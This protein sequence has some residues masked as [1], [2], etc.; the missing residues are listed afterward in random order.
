MGEY[1]KTLV[2]LSN[3]KKIIDSYHGA[4]ENLMFEMYQSN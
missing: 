3:L 2:Q 4:E 1:S